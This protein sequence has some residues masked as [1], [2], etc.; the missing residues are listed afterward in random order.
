MVF[1]RKKQEE[2]KLA[3]ARVYQKP[4]AIEVQEETSMTI[5]GK[6]RIVAIELFENGFRYVVIS[7]KRIGE[8][9]EEIPVD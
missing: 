7:N 8:I 5:A 1:F 9:G 3:E 4:K 6:A 2:E